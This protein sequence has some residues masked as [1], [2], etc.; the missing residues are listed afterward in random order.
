MAQTDTAWA[1]GRRDQPKLAVNAELMSE[2][3][4]LF[5]PDCPPISSILASTTVFWGYGDADYELPGGCVWDTEQHI[6]FCGDWCFDGRAEGAW[7]SGQAVVGHVL[8]R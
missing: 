3:S 4:R 7:A 6:G 5:G 8:P 2:F 1:T